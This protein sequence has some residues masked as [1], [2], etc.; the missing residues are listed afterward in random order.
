MKS[1]LFFLLLAV[2]SL[3]LVLA[4]SSEEVEEVATEVEVAKEA[5]DDHD[6]HDDHDEHEDPSP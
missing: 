3:T 6:D 4:C 5:K 1:K 2:M